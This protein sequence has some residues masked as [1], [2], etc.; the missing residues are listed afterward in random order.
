M[1]Q[2]HQ[3]LSVKRKLTIDCYLSKHRGIGAG[4]AIE[5]GR[6]GANVVVNYT[7]KR[8]AEAAEKVI[9]AIRRGGSKA[10][11][12]QANVS[13]L[14]DLQNLVK[15]AVEL[16]DSSKIDILVH[17]AGSGD[18]CYLADITE[19]FYESQSDIN[20]KGNGIARESMHYIS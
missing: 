20:L 3:G 7:S 5:L 12:V 8:G 16:S 14:A 13:K 9:D 11:L 6:R 18:D 4:I 15:A 1:S 2:A 17:N 19:D 10:E